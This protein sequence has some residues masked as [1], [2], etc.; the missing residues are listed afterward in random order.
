MLRQIEW[1][2]QSGPITKKFCQLTVVIIYAIKML[3][4]N[5]WEPTLIR[6][7]NDGTTDTAVIEQEGIY[8]TSL[9]PESLEPGLTFLTF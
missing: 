6:V 9:D 3:R 1:R 4:I 5:V 7:L 8:V 2:V